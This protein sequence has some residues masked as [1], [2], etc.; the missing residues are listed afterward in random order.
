M[1]RSAG[2]EPAFHPSEGRVLSVIRRARSFPILLKDPVKSK[3]LLPESSDLLLCARQESDLRPS[4]PQPD[5][6]S[7]ELRAHQNQKLPRLQYEG[8]LSKYAG[9]SPKCQL[10]LVRVCPLERTG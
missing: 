4:G 2:V 6:L 3:K 9:I 8:S 7:T 10:A 5:A 1:V